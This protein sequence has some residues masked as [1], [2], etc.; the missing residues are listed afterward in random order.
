[1]ACLCVRV[2]RPRWLQQA[3]APLLFGRG[4]MVQ[5]A[6]PAPT[7][8]SAALMK[9]RET[10]PGSWSLPPT[11]CR[12]AVHVVSF[13]IGLRCVWEQTFPA[14][15]Q[16]QRAL[17]CARPAA[18]SHVGRDAPGWPVGDTGH[19]E[20]AVFGNGRHPKRCHDACRCWTGVGCLRLRPPDATVRSSKT[21]TSPQPVPTRS[22]EDPTRLT[23][24]AT[25]QEASLSGSTGLRQEE[26]PRDGAR[27]THPPGITPA[28]IC[29][30]IG[31]RCPPDNVPRNAP[32]PTL[33]VSQAPRYNANRLRAR[34]ARAA[35]CRRQGALHTYRYRTTRLADAAARVR[36]H[37]VAVYQNI[38]ETPM[39]GLRWL[40]GVMA[41]VLPR[42]L[43]T[44][45]EA[46]ACSAWGR[47]PST[48]GQRAMSQVQKP[49]CMG[50]EERGHAH[51][52]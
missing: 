46:C 34:W 13:R 2:Q 39:L 18:L 5:C 30:S 16:V 17:Q 28:P 10:Q 21:A 3:P 47:Q 4:R 22:V 48:F 41:R 25:C 50:I 12:Q 44:V 20:P 43:G 36:M 45:Q 9:P 11:V 38:S 32:T 29:Q 26:A 7:P 15:R 40:D 37:V 24:A 42:H 49:P 8:R 1:M 35:P 27:Q 19:C 23:V 51:N 31:S 14:P 52:E 6:A 33:Q